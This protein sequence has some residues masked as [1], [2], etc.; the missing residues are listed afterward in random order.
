MSF[1]LGTFDV[2]V[3]NL[4]AP[5]PSMST[6]NID[7]RHVRTLTNSFKEFDHGQLFIV[8]GM[9][10][11][12][13][14]K[15]DNIQIEGTGNIEVLGG[16]HT[17]EAIQSLLKDGLLNKK[18]VKVNLYK[19]LPLTAALAIGYQHNSV[20]HEKKKPLTFMDKVNIMRQCR[21]AEQM[22]R[23]QTNEW[24]DRLLFIFRVKVI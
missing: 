13:E 14:M 17:R 7:I 2:H 11:N 8:V 9:L 10:T 18:T 6:R 16:N 1:L 12:E 3:S 21:P 23:Q 24:K 19:P 20:L 5:H 15:L 22:N 4:I